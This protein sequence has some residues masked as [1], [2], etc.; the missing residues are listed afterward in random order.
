[1]Y[2]TQP[3]SRATVMPP[4]YN[5]FVCEPRRIL[6]P[7]QGGS[8]C[9]RLRIAFAVVLA[10]MVPC[11]AFAQGG[12]SLTGVARDES[13]AVLPGVSVEA[14][15]PVLIEK[16]R[17]AVTDSTGRYTIIDVRPGEYTVTF[18]LTGFST[19]KREAVTVSGTG[20]I[21][22]DATRKIGN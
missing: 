12:A 18:T 15:S 22:V 3:I 4:R 20:A 6:Y 16:T 14:S 7:S 10:L 1:M 9:S 2:W 11:V 17:T 19:V 5:V 21:A 13:G 8:M